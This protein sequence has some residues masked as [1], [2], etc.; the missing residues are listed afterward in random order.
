MSN[1][2]YGICCG[3]QGKAPLRRLHGRYLVDYHNPFGVGN[4]DGEGTYPQVVLYKKEETKQVV[5]T[6]TDTD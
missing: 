3:C 4:C 6:S 5:E 2:L 1:Q